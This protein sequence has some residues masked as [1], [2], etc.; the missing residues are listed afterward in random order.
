M[1]NEI[2][3]GGLALV[4]MGVLVWSCRMLP[5]ERWQVLATMPVVRNEHGLWRG[6]NITYYGFF[7]A[8]AFAV[9]LALI[10]VMLGS[11]RMGILETL[12]VPVFL[13]VVCLPA[14]KWMARLWRK[15]PRP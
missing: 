5:G 1:I 8:C 10:L 14:S 6:L 15:S 2:V 7:Q 3:V 9:A 13:L 11:V 12:S 4:Y